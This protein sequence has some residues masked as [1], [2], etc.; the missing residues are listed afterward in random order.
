MLQKLSEQVRACLECAADARQKAEGTADWASRTNFLDMEKRWLAL[1]HSY[2]FVESHNGRVGVDAGPDDSLRLQEISTLLIQEGNLDALYH[3]VLDAAIDLM[4]ADFGSMQKFYPEREELR[5][6]AWRGFHPA[7]ATFWEWVHLGS[8]SA[9][10]AALSEG[11]RV[12]LPDIEACDFMTGTGDLEASHRSGIRAVQS[13]PLVSRSGQLLGMISTHWRQTHQPKERALRSLDVLAR[14]AAD[15]IE[16][17]QV[18]AALRESE[19]RFRWLGSIVESSDDAIISKNLDGIITSWNKGAERVFGYTVEE[20][21]GK[22]ITILIPADRRDEERMILER[23]KRGE[24]IEHFETVREHKLGSSVLVSL[25]ISP[26]KNADGRI[27]GASKIARDITEQRRTERELVEK[28]IAHMKRHDALTD[29]PNRVFL[30]ERLEKE[31]TYVRRG[32]RLAV[33][34]LH[35]DDFKSVND[36]LGHS[37]G[38]ELLKVAADR[39]RGCLGD[40]DFIAR[41]WGCE[42]AIVQT[43]LERPADAACL[44]QRLRDQMIRAPVELNGHQV[45][46][47]ISIGIALAPNDGTDADQLLKS[48]DMALHGAKSESR[49]S[50]RYFE[51]KMDVRMKARRALEAD[52]RKAIVNGE[53]EL[54]Y[55]PVVSLENNE[56]SGCEAILRWHHPVRGMIWPAE[57]IPVAEDT[58]LMIPIGEWVLRRACNDAAAWP[59][60][61]NVAVNVSAVQLR[62]ETW[63]QTVLTALEESGL[64]PHRL[65]LEITE[66]VLMQD[67]GATLR[68]LHQLRDLGV[69]IAMDDFGT[70]YSSLSY[71]R[72][73]PFHKI[74]ID[75]SFIDDLSNSV[76]CLKIVHAVASLASGLNMVTTAEGVETERQLEIIR[77][78]GCTE[79]QGYLFSP[80]RP[81]GEILQLIVPRTEGVVSA[82]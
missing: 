78:A 23:I 26:V 7:S 12:I 8:A 66:S 44:A 71:L 49:G 10:G 79:M 46:A 19:Q 17:S 53:F 31:L 28:R 68:M 9:C 69:R 70:G 1:A 51:P 21:I 57:F 77:A 40:T 62:D 45:V 30:R 32:G 33:L 36:T 16:R 18:E 14:Q 58:G 38:D 41:M 4:S 63:T 11:R 59:A 42:F 43:A 48:A 27:A 76:H 22:P 74:K 73:F 72:R 25:T 39:L 56:V 61:I 81:L 29:L 20:A 35:L 55:Q 54:Y 65:E 5:L 80:P 37:T 75:R 50:Y 47:D 13:T 64:P 2:E 60:E 6:L 3:R 15:L 24:R 52:L 34:C 67:N 82:A